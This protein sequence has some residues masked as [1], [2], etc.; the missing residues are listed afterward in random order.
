MLKKIGFISAGL[1][2]VNG[3]LVIV[4]MVS[5]MILYSQIEDDGYNV[6]WAISGFIGGL[7]WIM[8]GVFIGMLA[9]KLK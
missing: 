2:G 3:L 7:V 5:N 4:S 9:H 6:I 1:C 8:L